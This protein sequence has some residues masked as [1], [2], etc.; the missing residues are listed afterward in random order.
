MS[1]NSDRLKEEANMLDVFYALG[2]RLEQGYAKDERIDWTDKIMKAGDAYFVC[3]PCPTHQ[4]RHPSCLFKDGWNNVHCMSCGYHKNAID[5]IMD[6]KGVDFQ[7]AC[8]FLA[9]VEGNPSWYKFYDVKR[10]ELFRSQELQLLSLPPKW[11]EQIKAQKGEKKA[12]EILVRNANDLEKRYS[13]LGMTERVKAIKIL[14]ERG[15]QA[16]EGRNENVAE[17]K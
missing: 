17:S 16:Y 11:Y 4:D 1:K 10:R 5:V 7:E 6:V 12:L 3:C 14:K 15:L 2:Y 9:G 8:D 13:A